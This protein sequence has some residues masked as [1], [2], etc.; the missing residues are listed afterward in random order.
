MSGVTLLDFR[1]LNVSGVT[2]VNFRWMNAW[3]FKFCIRIYFTRDIL[4]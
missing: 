4:K 2:L 3:I 1:R